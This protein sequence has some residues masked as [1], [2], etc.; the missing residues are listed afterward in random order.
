MKLPGV[1]RPM[2]VVVAELPDLAP[3]REAVK[4]QG[5]SPTH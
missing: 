4:G 5:A 3:A 1:V 2:A